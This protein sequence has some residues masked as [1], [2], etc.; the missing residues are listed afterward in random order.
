VTA[1][2]Y[3]VTGRYGVEVTITRDA[4]VAERLSRLGLRVTARI[5]DDGDR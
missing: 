5:D 2:R 4:E 1:T 3:H